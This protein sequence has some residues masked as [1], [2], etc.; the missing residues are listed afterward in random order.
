[1][2]GL[3]LG[4]GKLTDFING[5]KPV[6]AEQLGPEL[7]PAFGPSGYALTGAVPPT[8]DANGI[9]F[10]GVSNSGTAGRTVAALEDDAN[11]KVVITVSGYVSGNFD[12]QIYGNTTSHLAQSATISSNGTH[13]FY[14]L[15]DLGAGSLTDLMR[16]RATGA[17]GT[18]TFNITGFS[19]RKVL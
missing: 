9:Y 10:N 7:A 11:Y 15:T 19:V 8:Q 18:N 14:L 6:A 3:G 5:Y 12:V 4:R 2:A 17:S 13:T 16:I 1:M